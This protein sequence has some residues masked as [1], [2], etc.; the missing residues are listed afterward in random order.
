MFY[1]YLLQSK[2]SG[3]LYTGFTT[4]LKKRLLE[5]NRGESKSTK[6]RSD[7]H[8]IYYEACLSESDARR[9]E[10][11]LKTSQGRFMLRRRIKDYLKSSRA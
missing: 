5:H 4:D 11:Y 1:V 2:K 6:K 10:D 9:R 8:C 3:D 7:W